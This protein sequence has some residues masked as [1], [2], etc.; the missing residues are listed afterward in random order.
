MK[1]L[2]NVLKTLFTPDLHVEK[3]R[4]TPNGISK[5]FI[6]WSI[7]ELFYSSPRKKAKL[8][9]LA[10]RSNEFQFF[11]Q[12]VGKFIFPGKFKWGSIFGDSRR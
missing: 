2:S 3:K 6:N 7:Y 11:Q 1:F 12:G 9:P 5:H 8:K 10:Y 4:Q